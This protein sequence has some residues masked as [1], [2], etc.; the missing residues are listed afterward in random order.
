M[1]KYLYILL[2]IIIA[3]VLGY[4]A[5][6]KL[7]DI[8]TN[9][10][11]AQ[12]TSQPVVIEPSTLDF[13]DFQ[14][15]DKKISFKYPSDWE[16]QTDIQRLIDTIGADYQDPVQKYKP[17]FLF[18]AAYVGLGDELI[19]FQVIKYQFPLSFDRDTI[20]AELFKAR[21]D[22]SYQ[23]S[24]SSDEAGS[25]MLEVIYDISSPKQ[26]KLHTKEK[27]FYSKDSKTQYV[28][29]FSFVTL[30][31]DWVKYQKIPDYI[32]NSIKFNN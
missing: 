21:Q 27:Y 25:R 26:I 4:F 14:T 9:K 12:K 24:N 11:T 7:A 6:I 17:Q 19:N 3:L 30:E 2:A 15:Q 1:R 22:V 20:Q 23:I 18:D 31:Q 5:Y 16:P 13:S 10:I 29:E 28:Y 32:F 8:R